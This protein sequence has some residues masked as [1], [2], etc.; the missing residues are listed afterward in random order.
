MLA[1]PF[2]FGLF[3]AKNTPCDESVTNLCGNAIFEG[4]PK[5]RF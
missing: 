2:F 3:L 5:P 4:W 1:G